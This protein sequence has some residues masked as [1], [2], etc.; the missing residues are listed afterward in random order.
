[1]DAWNRFSYF[2]KQNCTENAA[3]S[4]VENTRYV[5]LKAMDLRDGHIWVLVFLVL[6]MAY[7]YHVIYVLQ[8]EVKHKSDHIFVSFIFHIPFQFVL[9]KIT[10]WSIFFMMIKRILWTTVN[11][12]LEVYQK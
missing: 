3:L 10:I 9:N 5:K 12:T 1:M 8:E 6:S 4:T 2:P 7:M 11:E